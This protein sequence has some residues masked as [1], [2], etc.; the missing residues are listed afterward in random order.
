MFRL[1][2][3]EWRSIDGIGEEAVALLMPR[4]EHVVTRAA[5]TFANAIKRTLTGRRTGTPVKV[6]KDGK[7][8]RHIPS[9][10]GEPPAVLF[11]NL[12]N[13]VG[14]NRAQT[15]GY[16]VFAEVGVGLGVKPKGGAHD[17]ATTYARRLERGGVDKRGVRI[18]PRPYIEPTETAVAAKLDAILETL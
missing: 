8:K 16:I 9:R 3:D 10:P 4:A 6:T 2:A 7:S 13:S 15:V 1:T 17:P 18:L 5:L 12:R 11:G 14:A